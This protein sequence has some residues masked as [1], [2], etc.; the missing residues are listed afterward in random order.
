MQALMT[1]RRSLGTRAS[2]ALAG[3]LMAILMYAGMAAVTVSKA[4][5]APFCSAVNLAP[6]GSYGDRCFA[7]VWEADNYV[8]VAVITH[9]RAGCVTYADANTYDLQGSWVCAGNYWEAYK[10]LRDD[11][12]NYRG[13]IR[14]NNLNNPGRFDGFQNCCWN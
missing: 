7:W 14:N 5:A 6:Y 11:G 2:L 10:V 1:S 3:L 12:R 9:E 4:S 13:V 8:T